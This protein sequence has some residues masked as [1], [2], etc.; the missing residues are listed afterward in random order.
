MKKTL[1]IGA[2]VLVLASATFAAA[3]PYGKR[4]GFQGACGPYALNNLDLTTEQA[5]EL[6]AL[7]QSNFSQMQEIRNKLFQKRAELRLAWMQIEP[8]ADRIKS[9][10]KEVNDL[11]AQR[12]EN[13]VDHRLAVRNILTPEQLS[14]HLAQSGWGGKDI[15]SRG[16][17]R[18]SH[19]PR[20]M[21]RWN[22]PGAQFGP[23]MWTNPP[24]VQ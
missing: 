19:R 12:Q 24:Q 10:Q 15:R 7:R 5:Q 3:G 11:M 1:L 16:M 17:F 2:L 22:G 14:Q 6:L 21:N 8:D 18:N 4:S 13:M 9:L 20:G 23:G